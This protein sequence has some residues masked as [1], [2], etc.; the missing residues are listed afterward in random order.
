MSEYTI[1]LDEIKLI[2]AAGHKFLAEAIHIWDLDKGLP[3]AL[4]FRFVNKGKAAGSMQVWRPRHDRGQPFR[5]IIRARCTVNVEALRKE[6]WDIYLAET[7]SHEI[8]HLVCNA[9]PHLGA[10]HNT[11]WQDVHRT[12]GGSGEQF[13]HGYT[14]TPARVVRKWRYT[15]TEGYHTIVSTVR[16]NR[17]QSGT[18]YRIRDTSTGQNKGQISPSCHFEEVQQ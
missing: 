4:E 6:G 8:A 17:I 18:I 7:I 13:Y 3:K 11:G 9:A 2:K 14:L 1:N 10:K 16:H 15:T 5:K 12:L